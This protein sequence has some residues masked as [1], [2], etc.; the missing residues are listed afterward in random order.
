MVYL[1]FPCDK[2]IFKNNVLLFCESLYKFSLHCE[3]C[4]TRMIQNIEMITPLYTS[5][6]PCYIRLHIS[7][8]L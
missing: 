3:A 8:I 6:H 1:Q 2:N 4:N 5:S 7:Q